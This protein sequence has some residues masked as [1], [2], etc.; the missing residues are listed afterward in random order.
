V[1]QSATSGSGTGFTCTVTLGNEWFIRPSAP[2]RRTVNTQTAP[3]TLQLADDSNTIFMN[4]AAAA[5]VYVR[6]DAPVGFKTTIIQGGAG[7]IT[8]ALVNGGSIAAFSGTKTAGQNAKIELEVVSN[9]GSA[10]VV[11]ISGQLA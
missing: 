4:V 8:P 10:P 9:P 7:Q 1:A 11:V 6:P 5:K 2:R 3:Y